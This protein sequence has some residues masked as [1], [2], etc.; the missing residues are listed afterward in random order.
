ME[1]FVWGLAL[2]AVV[3]IGKVAWSAPKLYQMLPN[4]VVLVAFI[5]FQTCFQIWDFAIRLDSSKLRDFAPAKSAEMLMLSETLTVPTSWWIG[6]VC[7]FVYLMLLQMLAA[8]KIHH[9]EKVS[10]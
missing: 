4:W 2:A 1:T 6:L 9:D 7:G 8:L 3:G 10:Q 5:I